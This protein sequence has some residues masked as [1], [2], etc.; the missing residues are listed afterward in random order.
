[1]QM[2]W[3][4]DESIDVEGM[5]PARGGDRVT[6]DFDLIGQK[7]FPSI[8]Q[9]DREEPASSGNEC[10]AIVGYSQAITQPEV[11]AQWWITLR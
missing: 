8:E 1:M 3:Q 4:N 5:A 9:V 11:G 6:Q 10:A 7:G 2:I